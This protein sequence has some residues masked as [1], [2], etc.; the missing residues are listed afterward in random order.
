VRRT[1]AARINKSPERL[2]V[3]KDHYDLLVSGGW[4]A[5]FQ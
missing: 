3:Q 2:A 5:V 4:L 1:Q